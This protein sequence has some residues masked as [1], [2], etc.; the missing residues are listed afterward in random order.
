MESENHT[1]EHNLPHISLEIDRSLLVKALSAVAIGQADQEFGWI[2]IYFTEEDKIVFSASNANASVRYEIHSPHQGSGIIKITGK[3]LSDYTKQLPDGNISCFINLPH[4]AVMKSAGSTAKIQ[5]IQD[6]SQ[7]HV[8]PS[9]PDCTITVKGRALERWTSSYR[10]FILS[11]SGRFFCNGA[12]IFIDEE[13]KY[14]TAIATDA[15]CLAKSVLTD[16]YRDVSENPKSLGEQAAV[17][18][19]K[20]VIEEMKKIGSESPDQDYVLK[21][22]KNFQTFSIETQGYLLST[23]CISGNYPPYDSA[24]PKTQSIQAVIGKKDFQDSIRRAIIFSDKNR[25]VTLR[26]NGDD[27]NVLTSTKGRKEGKEV[28]KISSN[29]NT[30][31][32]SYNGD[33][34]LAV[35]NVLLGS[36]AKFF[37]DDFEK[38]FLARGE[39]E[40]DIDVFYLVVPARLS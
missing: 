32:I 31:E 13:T 23:S 19:S 29:I 22:S 10:D 35:L 26:I 1:E 27:L 21:W 4:Q 38:P 16:G 39:A 2:Q 34:L 30:A 14:L 6:Y 8:N 15:H 33:H 18:I 12:L 3:Q 20:R 36:Q 9:V 40:R 28:L 7:V 11:D 24:M 17:L 25:I 5:L 37:W